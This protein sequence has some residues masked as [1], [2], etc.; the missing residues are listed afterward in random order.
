[1]GYGQKG[2]PGEPAGGGGAVHSSHAR[3]AADSR[4]DED[5]PEDVREATVGA[6]RRTPHPDQDDS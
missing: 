6:L 1:M 4:F 2:H 5:P 3:Q